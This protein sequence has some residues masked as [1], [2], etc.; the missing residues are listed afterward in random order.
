MNFIVLVFMVL[1]SHSLAFEDRKVQSLH[2]LT[3]P[4]VQRTGAVTKLFYVFSLSSILKV[5][6]Y[7]LRNK[8]IT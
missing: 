8:Y 6:A 7:V 3:S 2:K 1:T 5:L 4:H